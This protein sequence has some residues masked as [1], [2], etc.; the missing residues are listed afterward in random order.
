LDEA[1]DRFRRAEVTAPSSCKSRAYSQAPETTE[2]RL[3]VHR[4]PRGIDDSRFG[5]DDT[6]VESGLREAESVDKTDWSASD[7]F[8]VFHRTVSAVARP[9]DIR[10]ASSIRKLDFYRGVAGVSRGG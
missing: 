7:D 8:H 3:E 1:R 9:G 4:R 5:F 10:V 6:R 2:N